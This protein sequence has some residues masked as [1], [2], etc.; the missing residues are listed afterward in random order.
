ME[1]GRIESSVAD[2]S[3][4]CQIGSG[5]AQASGSYHTSIP[6]SSRS[7]GAPPSPGTHQFASPHDLNPAAAT[8]PAAPPGLQSTTTIASKRLYSLPLDATNVSRAK[9]TK[10]APFRRPS[11]NH[12]MYQTKPHHFP[13]PM[14]RTRHLSVEPLNSRHRHLCRRPLKSHIISL[15]PR[16]SLDNQHAPQTAVYHLLKRNHPFFPFA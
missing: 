4:P 14:R 11:K 2:H 7:P 3:F 10:S 13:S 5:S 1:L 12:L 8:S 15:S 6:C 16:L 9:L